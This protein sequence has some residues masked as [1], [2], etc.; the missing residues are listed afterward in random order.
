MS[1]KLE[2]LK[3]KWP[4]GDKFLKQMREKLGPKIIVAFST[5]KDAVA[6]SIEL[7]RHFE[8]VIPFSCYYVPG[9]RIMEDAIEYYEEN[10]FKRKIIRAPHPVFIEWLSAFRYQTPESAKEIARSG[11][12]QSLSFEAIVRDLAEE[13]GLEDQKGMYAV[14]ARSG[15]FFTRAVM[16]SKSGGIQA[17]RRQWW[18]VWHMTKADVLNTIKGSNLA[19][20][21]EYELFATSFCGLDYGFMSQFA[22][23]EPEDFET[24]KRWFPLIELELHRFDRQS[25]QGATSR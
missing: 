16:C 6:M 8:E 1:I 2:D 10:L 19:I 3:Q 21:R 25:K 22:K 11:L 15:E 5:G 20:S 12:P 17:A 24:I 7:M 13:H 23:H 4:H 14:G 18:P 9:L